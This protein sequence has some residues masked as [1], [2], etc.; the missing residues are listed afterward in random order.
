MKLIDEIRRDHRLVDRV[1]GSLVA[2]AERGPDHDDAADDLG[3]LVLFYR[4]FVGDHHHRQEARLFDALVEHA[5][6]PGHRGPLVVLAREHDEIAAAVGE[7]ERA[8]C[9]QRSPAIA[10]RIAAV[11][12]QHVDKEESVFLPVAERRLI[13]GGI[14]EIDPLPPTA[15][16]AAARAAGEELIRRLPPADDPNVIRGDGCIPCSAFGDTCH[17]IETEWWSDWE[18]EHHASLGEG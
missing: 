15:E 16:S 1:A 10:R 17:G 7:L 3:S 14:R 5:E 4:A 13:D 18:R 11:S 2:W 8:G 9:G 12:R 6:V